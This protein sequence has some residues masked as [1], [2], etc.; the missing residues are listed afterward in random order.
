[1]HHWPAIVP[2]KGSWRSKNNPEVYVGSLIATYR[3]L[4]I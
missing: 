3:S 1:M 4:F 2:Y